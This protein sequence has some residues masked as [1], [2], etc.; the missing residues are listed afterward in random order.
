MSYCSENRLPLNTNR[1]RL[2]E[3]IELLGY[4]KA[5]DPLKID[6][7]LASYLYKETNEE[8]S[9]VELE[10]YVYKY[11]DCIS[12]QTR[13]R[14]GRSYWDLKQQNKTISLLKSVFGGDFSTDEGN[15]RYLS[16]D[17]EEPSKLECSLFLARWRLHNAIMN[18]KV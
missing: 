14:M 18:A 13:T 15:N 2:F 12:V 5:K 16:F 11:D 10:L 17:V 1:R 7:Q 9:F 3:I 6:G 8:I 4:K